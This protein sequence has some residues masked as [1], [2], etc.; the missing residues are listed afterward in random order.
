MSTRRA[1]ALEMGASG[2]RARESNAL[3]ASL[4]A[5]G[6]AYERYADP[7]TA[8]EALASQPADVLLV[9]A[10]S[11]WLDLREFV[12]ALRRYGALMEQEQAER[13]GQPKPLKRPHRA[14]S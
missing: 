14:G 12:E 5:R 4:S 9:D 11:P 13:A 1:V 3:A 10:D 2:P 7:R 6:F 8:F